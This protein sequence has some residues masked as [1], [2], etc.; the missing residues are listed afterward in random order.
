MKVENIYVKLVKLMASEKLKLAAWEDQQ[1][2]L[3]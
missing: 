2:E 1:A 3:V